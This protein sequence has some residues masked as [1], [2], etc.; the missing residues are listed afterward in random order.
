MEKTKYS[1]DTPVFH[2]VCGRPIGWTWIYSLK[3]FEFEA[4]NHDVYGAWVEETTLGEFLDRYQEHFIWS[5][6]AGYKPSELKLNQERETVKPK[7]KK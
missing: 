2:I 6:N 3:K 1:R 4:D 7:R 5:L